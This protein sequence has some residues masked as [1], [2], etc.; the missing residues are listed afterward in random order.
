MNDG[1][2]VAPGRANIVGE[3]TDYN[4]GYALPIAISYVVRCTASIRDDRFVVVESGLYPGETVRASIAELKTATVPQW[5]RYALGVVHEFVERG[6]DV[7]GL[8]LHIE[9]D[10]PPGAGLSSSAAVECAVATA[11]RDLADL[12]ISDADLIDLASAAE[13][14][15]VGAPTGKLDQSAAILSKADHALFLDFAT[16]EH[17]Y[18]PFALAG[19]GVEL[20]VIDTR[21]RHELADGGYAERRGQCEAA[22]RLLGVR[23]LRAATS[24]DAIDDDVL[25]RRARHV[26]TDNARVV[27]A[28]EILR[29]GSDIRAI[30]PVLTESHCSLRDDFEV[31]TPELDAAVDAA[32]EVG[33]FG[34]R[35]MGG[36]FGGSAIALVDSAVRSAVEAE[37]AEAFARAD[38][39]AP[40]VFAVTAVT[41]ARRLG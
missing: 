25:R 19:S 23:T 14:D 15:Y 31:S 41:G 12:D 27:A 38:Y 10:I 18:V 11:V 16:G 29:S 30:G 4:A 34:A 9:S 6:H 5:S 7:P 2:W 32:L 1:V 22:A 20:L 26:I 8:T 39:P 36:G 17:E 33:A 3:H 40:A 24:A 28:A 35:M 13:N 21:T 37:I